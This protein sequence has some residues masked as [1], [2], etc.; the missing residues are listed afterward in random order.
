M[1]ITE[2]FYSID[3]EG[4]RTGLPVIFIRSFGCN[5]LCSYCDSHYAVLPSCTK[6]EIKEMS[7]CEILDAIKQWPCK[8]VTLTGGEPL[9]QRDCY[10]LIKMLLEEQY[11]V[12]VE[13]NGSINPYTLNPVNSDTLEE[14]YLNSDRLFFTFDYKCPTSNQED[15]M[16]LS[17]LKDMKQK[18]V[19]KFVVG[20]EEDLKKAERIVSYY[21]PKSQIYLSPVFGKIKSSDIVEFIKESD[22]LLAANAR[23]Q[24][25]LHKFIWDVNQIGV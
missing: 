12:N 3:G 15:K 5:M 13:T 18:D 8:R 2:L 17:I 22:A 16:D 4:T 24:L 21:S 6:T 19:L 25:Q 7:A 1:Q 11:E 23:M 14:E 20:S 9:L 10:T